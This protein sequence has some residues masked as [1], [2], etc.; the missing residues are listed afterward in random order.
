MGKSANRLIFLFTLRLLPHVLLSWS[1]RGSIWLSTNISSDSKQL[2]LNGDRANCKNNNTA[3]IQWHLIPFLK[4]LKSVKHCLI[5]LSNWS[6]H[7]DSYPATLSW[8][9]SSYIDTTSGHRSQLSAFV[10]SFFTRHAW[11]TLH[12]LFNITVIHVPF[13]FC[14]VRTKHHSWRPPNSCMSLK[15]RGYMYT[16]QS[17]KNSL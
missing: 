4:S 15:K 5:H 3:W 7:K 8:W 2:G 9:I 14:T 1:F 16:S 11:I 17:I 13:F 10:F 6:S 12:P